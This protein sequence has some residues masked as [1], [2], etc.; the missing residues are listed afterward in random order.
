M[1]F[2]MK[3]VLFSTHF[4]IAFAIS[5]LQP[6]CHADVN[7]LFSRVCFT[8]QLRIL[9]QVPMASFKVMVGLTG[10][11]PVTPRL[12]SVCSNQLSYRPILISSPIDFRKEVGGGTGTRTPD[13]QLAKLALYQLSYTP[14]VGSVPRFFR[15]GRHARRDGHLFHFIGAWANAVS[16]VVLVGLILRFRRPSVFTA[17]STLPFLRMAYSIERR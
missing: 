4:G 9:C 10:L 14:L 15:K 7:L 5:A 3:I 6:F 1:F 17:G 2:V 8:K 12:S 13:I 11:E 16:I